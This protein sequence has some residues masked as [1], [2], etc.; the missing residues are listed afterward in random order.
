MA[1]GKRRGV[2]QRLFITT[3]N[4]PKSPGHPFYRKLNELLK[5]IDFD[6]K[7]EALC[8]P[9]Y[10]KAGRPSIPPGVYFRM[11]IIG[12]FEGLDSQRAIAWRC[13]DSLSIR[14]FLGLAIDAESPDHS[15]LTVIRKR[16]PLEVHQE[17]FSLILALAQK[18][19]LLKA[20][21]AGVDSTMLEANAAMKSIV[22]RDTCEDW[23]G[24]IKRLAVEEGMSNP[25]D[26]DARRLD[27][28]REGKKVSNTDWES[29]SD[30]DSR[31][32]KMK[33]GRTHLAYKAEHVVDLESEF[34][35]AAPVYRADQADTSTMP[36]SLIEAGVNLAQAGTDLAIAEVAADKG[37]HKAET[38][39][40]CQEQLQVRT[41]VPERRRS[42]VRRWTDKPAGWQHAVL[43]NRRRVRGRHS[44]QLQRRRSERVERSFAH[45]C[46]SGRLRRAWIRGL[47]EVGKRYVIQAA[48][49]NLGRVMFL[50]FQ[51]GSARGLMGTS[52]ARLVAFF[53]LWLRAAG[54]TLISI[55]FAVIHGI[56]PARNPAA[57]GRYCDRRDGS[58]TA[59]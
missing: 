26:E 40:V 33:D 42:R 11:L 8:E 16:L 12:Y 4:L 29:P 58:S 36:Q 24:Y 15:S 13:K 28:A 55:F 56:V 52:F 49:R 1:L 5:E 50:L 46:T 27:R 54:I 23:K 7:A 14:E 22:R 51:I 17:I 9:H 48:A 41:Y 47:G 25:T 10:A 44:K 45:T 53:A 2:Q 31:I 21:V 18:L 43:S 30:P 6:V 32:A 37:Y 57:P 39:A 19:D 59:C 34:I 3:S 20:K 38:L 35:L